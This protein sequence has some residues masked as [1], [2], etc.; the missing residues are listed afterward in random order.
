M[1]P[2]SKEN[3]LVIFF[4]KNSKVSHFDNTISCKTP[5]LYIPW[6]RV[7]H[8]DHSMCYILLSTLS[9]ECVPNY[10]NIVLYLDRN[11]LSIYCFVYLLL[12]EFYVDASE[13]L[14][15]LRYQPTQ[16]TPPSLPSLKC[17]VALDCRNSYS[18]NGF[19][20]IDVA[21]WKCWPY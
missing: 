5:S 18:S 6:S 14:F 3:N 7:G 10:L 19:F 20:K 17:L 13:V 8:S 15:M 21:F 4:L 2:K 12:V 11:K 9:N 1:T 16:A